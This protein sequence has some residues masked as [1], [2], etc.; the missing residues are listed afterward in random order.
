MDITIVQAVVLGIVQ[1]VTEFLPV[2]S[3]GHIV[4]AQYFFGMADPHIAFVV[5]LHVGSLFA[6]ILYFWR[7]WLNLFHIKKDMALYRDNPY[8][9]WFVVVATIPAVLCGLF[10]G[11]AM[12][13]MVFSEVVVAFL[14]LCGSAILFA[15]D[16]LC[17]HTKTLHDMSVKK[18]LIIGI[19]QVVALVP[20]VSRSGMTIAGARVC[21]INRVDAARFSFLLSAPIIFGAGIMMMRDVTHV[22]LTTQMIVGMV[23]SCIVAVATIHYF[24][25]LIRK[26]SY[27]VFLYYSIGFFVLVGIISYL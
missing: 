11:D 2:S 17:A 18:A 20:G 3:S 13:K 12:E 6:V 10:V 16:R 15:C 24:L 27:A 23:V 8:L 9:L 14:I 1:G 25:A 22:A 26:I 19:L 4:L 5:A 21:G 7:D